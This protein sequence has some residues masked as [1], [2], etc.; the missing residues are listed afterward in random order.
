MRCRSGAG[1]KAAV[2]G[3]LSGRRQ[4]LAGENEMACAW[5]GVGGRNPG[6]KTVGSHSRAYEFIKTH[7]NA[8]K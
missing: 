2:C 1:V 8:R 4:I 3:F 6:R 7:R 5:I